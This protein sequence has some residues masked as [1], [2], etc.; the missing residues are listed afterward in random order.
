MER[1]RRIAKDRYT[2][3]TGWIRE[4]L[5]EISKLELAAS[6]RRQDL[7]AL[8]HSFKK[9]QFVMGTRAWKRQDLCERD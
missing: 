2:T 8:E 7:E 5:L 4:Y 9:F 6:R 1:V 3:L